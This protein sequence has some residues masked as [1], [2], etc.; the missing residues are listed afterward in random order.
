MR[1]L[2]VVA[3][4]ASIATFFNACSTSSD[5]PSD[6]GAAPYVGPPEPV[7][8]P[9]TPPNEEFGPSECDVEY[10]PDYC[11]DYHWP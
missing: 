4:V 7:D 1:T 6:G 10:D 11:G 8:N 2:V 5:P 9:G 3:L